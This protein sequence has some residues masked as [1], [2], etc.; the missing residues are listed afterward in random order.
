MR[1]QK[2]NRSHDTIFEQENFYFFC[3]TEDQIT[4]QTLDDY[5]RYA[6]F[7]LRFVD[8]DEAIRTN[9]NYCSSDPFD[10][11]MI[12]REARVLQMIRD[13]LQTFFLL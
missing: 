8:I 5:E 10:D 6:E 9:N 3:D 11:I 1:R 12:R 7:V 13:T 2:S 4:E